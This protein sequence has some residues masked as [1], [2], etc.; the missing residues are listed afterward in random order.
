LLTHLENL[1]KTIPPISF[2]IA[3]ILSESEKAELIR[4]I[5][6]LEDNLGAS[7][8]Q[9]AKLIKQNQIL[10]NKVLDQN[11]S[12]FKK[13]EK[14]EQLSKDI[15]ALKNQLNQKEIENERYKKSK[16]SLH[17]IIKQKD[18]RIKQLENPTEKEV[19]IK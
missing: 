9:V 14:I 2:E 3:G 5:S 6:Q 18:N 10:N 12:I 8:S 15:K 19:R 4:K 13:D 7:S 1:Q 11:V 17:K 16:D